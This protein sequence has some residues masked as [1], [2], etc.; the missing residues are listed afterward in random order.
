MPVPQNKGELLKAIEHNFGNLIGDLNAVPEDLVDQRSLDGHVTG[1]LMSVS[2][3]LAYLVGWNE[4]V[5]KWLAKDAAGQPIDFP[6]SGYKWNELGKL[7]QKFYRDYD[8]I[9]Y[10]QLLDRLDSAKRQIVALIETRS[11]EQLYGGVWYEKWSMGRM[12]QF[13]T[14]SPYDNARRR[15]RKWNKAQAILRNSQAS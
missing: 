3:L 13:N 8:D 2:N 5:L 9:P 15:L 12:I 11:D 7:A 14:S 6:D 10:Q 1:S 4:L